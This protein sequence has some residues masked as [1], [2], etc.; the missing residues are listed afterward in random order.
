MITTEELREIVDYCPETGIMTKKTTGRI[1][2]VRKDGRVAMFL[3]GK[4]YY[5]HRLAWLYMT[6]DWPVDVCD[7]RNG[8]PSDNRWAN[9]RQATRLQN[10]Q[11][12]RL[13]R[14]STS[15]VKG[16]YWHSKCRKWASHINDRGKTVHLGVFRERSDAEQAVRK[17][18]EEI[19]GEFARH[20]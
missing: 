6:G 9:L 18:R 5:V 16:V 11:N 2:R 14:H 17:Y 20:E 7:H 4:T 3:L 15:G 10:N 8:N 13:S 12:Q 19:H 1:A